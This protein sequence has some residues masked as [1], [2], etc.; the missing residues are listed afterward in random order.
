[1]FLMAAVLAAGCSKQEAKQ[2]AQTTT[3]KVAQKVQEAFDDV[4]TPVGK[5]DPNAAKQREQ[6]RFDQRWRELQSFRAQQQAAA[7]AQQQ[8]QQQQQQQKA[9][10][11]AL[12]IAFV[13]GKKETFK[14]AD[15]QKINAAPVNVPIT[16]D[17]RGPSVLR[18][19]VLLDRAHYAVGVIDGRWGRNS[20]IAVW[21]WQRAHGIQP[22]G[23][24]DEA[25]FRSIAQA[26]GNVEP[27]VSHTLT[28]DDVKGPFVT[29][30]EEVYDQES[31]KCLCYESLREKLAERFHASE[32]FLE[33]LNPD[34]D[35]SSLAAGTTINVP[36]VREPMTADQRDIAKIVV[37]IAGNSL[38]GYD[39]NGG[40]IFHAPT[41][42]GAGYDPSPDETV[43][44]AKIVPDPHFHYDPKLYHEVSDDKPDAHL[45]P[46]PNSP[47]GVVWIAL[48][49]PH[50]GIHGTKDPDSIGYASSHG[51]VRLTNYDADELRRRISEGVAVAFVDT[52]SKNLPEVAKKAS[53]E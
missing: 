1:M 17:Q 26:A 36:N 34:V 30:P 42:V 16:G 2:T 5:P 18:A 29:I 7:A 48:S 11:Q 23:D 38:N 43:Q 13:T 12:Q 25:T 35:F 33:V 10:E 27:V 40:L 37:S 22:T 47:V 3:A 8:Q 21:W 28:E 50:Y 31:L 6:E 15:P 4:S 51:C 24:I 32:D 44:V 53:G 52:S 14:G 19:Q 39:A 9:A 41:T 46:G 45:N 20:A 49:K